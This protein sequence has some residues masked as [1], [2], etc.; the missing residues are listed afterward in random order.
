MPLEG[1]IKVRRRTA[2][3]AFG[4]LTKPVWPPRI[5][6]QRR[7]EAPGKR[8][9]RPMGELALGGRSSGD[10]KAARRFS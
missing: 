7:A 6:V 1:Y 2:A 4:S 10:N 9:C 5:P 3:H 8:D